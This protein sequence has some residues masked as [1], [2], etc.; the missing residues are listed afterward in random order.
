MTFRMIIR[1]PD[2][3][4][5]SALAAAKAQVAAE[6]EAH[7]EAQARA[8]NYGSG[9]QLASYL[10]SGVPQWAAEARAFVAW[11]DRVWSAA[12]AA[13]HEAREAGSLPDAEKVIAALPAFPSTGTA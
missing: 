5:V 4:A 11:R 9:A 10:D 6:V 1:T 13:L 7:V 8:L 3:I 12:L 2:Q